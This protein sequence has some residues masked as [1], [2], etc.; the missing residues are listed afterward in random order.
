[1]CRLE[2][3]GGIRVRDGVIHRAISFAYKA[4][5]FLLVTSLLTPVSAGAWGRL[6]HDTI[7]L[8]AESH[9]DPMAAKSVAQL[10]GGSSL[11]QVASWADAARSSTEWKHTSGYHFTT[12][13]DDFHYYDEI[14]LIPRAQWGKGDAIRLLVKAE[15]VL[16]DPQ[17]SD[18]NKSLALKFLVH[19]LG[20]LHQPLHTG[21]S[22]DSGGNAIPVTWFGIPSNLHNVWDTRM[23]VSFLALH[24]DIFDS[25]DDAANYVTLLPKPTEQQLAKWQ[26]DYF[27]EWHEES[28][29]IRLGAYGDRILSNEE[30]LKRKHAQVNLR[31]LQAGVRLAAILNSVFT[32]APDYQ[33]PAMQLRQELANVFGPQFNDLISLRPASKRATFGPDDPNVN[34]GV[35]WGVDHDCDS[36]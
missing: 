24:G 9:L 12:T 32:G 16:R 26:S 19:M 7:A 36:H 30:Y 13:R 6:G 17:Q 10:L 4:S 35:D 1:M 29:R 11:R 15:D 20:D 34:W 2:F 28:V 8:V 31:I 21:R 18:L 22:E 27:L 25:K 14:L 23:S 5:V 33:K 3:Q